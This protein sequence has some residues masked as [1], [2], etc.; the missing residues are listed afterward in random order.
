M[1]ELFGIQRRWHHAIL[2]IV[3]GCVCLVQLQ[4]AVRTDLID[5]DILL[6]VPVTNAST[7]SMISPAD[8]IAADF[9]PNKPGVFWRPLTRITYRIG[10]FLWGLYPAYALL[11]WALHLLVLFI[12]YRFARRVLDFSHGLALIAVIG[13]SAAFCNMEGVMQLASTGDK[14]LLIFLLLGFMSKGV[15]PHTLLCI[16]SIMAKEP[17]VMY[18]VIVGGF[19]LLSNPKFWRV[20][21]RQ[22]FPAFAISFLYGLWFLHRLNAYGHIVPVDTPPE[23][24]FWAIWIVYVHALAANL[25]PGGQTIMY[26]PILG[27]N[28]AHYIDHA[29][30]PAL[31][32]L[33]FLL[34][35]IAFFTLLLMFLR[36]ARNLAYRSSNHPQRDAFIIIAAQ[37]FLIMGYSHIKGGGLVSRYM[38]IANAFV[39]LALACGIDS[40]RAHTASMGRSFRLAIRWIAALVFA[41]WLVIQAV[42]Y[43]ASP[44]IDYYTRQMRTA[45]VQALALREWV[46]A[47]RPRAG[48]M[49]VLSE[50]AYQGW[51]F[52]KSG[53]VQAWG[54][55]LMPDMFW[56]RLEEEVPRDAPPPLPGMPTYWLEWMAEDRTWRLAREA[57]PTAPPTTPADGDSMA[58]QRVP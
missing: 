33:S 2:Y 8:G 7:G 52:Y 44:T 26:T 20:Q 12:I 27:Q 24:G 34:G 5:D 23:R 17:G 51:T 40:V 9:V 53:Q 25:I 10:V 47:H 16:G 4:V 35:I 42:E 28:A 58:S 3:L 36:A 29:H 19:H 48:S 13:F 37:V 50:T 39:I 43:I 15:I 54:Q 21:F 11:S 49:L 1:P 30:L 41:C 56:V 18:P 45:R 46:F 57:D 6:I 55:V 14:Y 31:A 22:L 32:T 38:Y